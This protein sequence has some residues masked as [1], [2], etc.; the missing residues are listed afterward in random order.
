[1][2][3]GDPAV[4]LDYASGRLRAAEARECEEH[5]TVCAVCREIAV[6][7]RA[8]WVAMDDWSEVEVSED[9]DRRLYARIAQAEHRRR[10]PRAKLWPLVPVAAALAIATLIE[11]PS[12]PPI[13]ADKVD[14]EQVEMALDDL[15]MLERLGAVQAPGM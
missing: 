1:M 9:F 6:V 12:E 3:N 11:W 5:I 15:D 2:K 4:L 10:G 8:V 14:I 13:K 7:Q